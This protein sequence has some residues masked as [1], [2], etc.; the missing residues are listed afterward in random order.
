MPTRFDAAEAPLLRMKVVG[1]STDHEVQERLD[2]LT[3]YLRERESGALL[4]D[5]SDSRPLSAKQRKLRTDWLASHGGLVRAKC[6]GVA[7][8]V[9]S[10][11]VR[12]VFTAAFW[13]WPPPMPY[14]FVDG[15]AEGEVWLR[16][17][18]HERFAHA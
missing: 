14:V 3:R 15:A 13:V 5:A 11:L 12:G 4:F 1:P 7:F 16:A 6:V 9:T 10:P 18:L 17:R 8:V 2:W